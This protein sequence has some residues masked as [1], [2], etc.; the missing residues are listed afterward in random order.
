MQQL[1]LFKGK[2]Q[3]GVKPPAAPEFNLHVMTADTLAR[4]GTRGWRVTH[5]ASGEWRHP[6]TA[7][8]LKRMGVQKGWADFILLSP[9]P[10]RTHFLELKRRKGVLS[11]EQLDFQTWCFDNGV[12]YAVCDNYP[13]VLKRLRDWG[14]VRVAVTA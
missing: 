12:E 8:R 7:A 9:R 2:R 5:I 13:D 3:R 1:H 10:S 11:D 14:A 4:W 6:I